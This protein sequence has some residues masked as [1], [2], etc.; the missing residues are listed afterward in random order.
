MDQDGF[1]PS[2]STLPELHSPTEL[3][4]RKWTLPDSNRP[5]APCKGAALPDELRARV[6]A[7]P[8]LPHQLI[9]DGCK[10]ARLDPGRRLPLPHLHAVG[11]PGS[12]RQGLVLPAGLEPAASTFEASRS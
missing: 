1:E 9:A 2:T 3:Q 11:A 7:T 12:A 5:P 6:S 4:A 8:G 10:R